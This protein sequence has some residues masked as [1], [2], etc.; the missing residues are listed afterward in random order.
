MGSHF[1]APPGDAAHASMMVV[2]GC[3]ADADD[4]DNACRGTLCS[5]R[6]PSSSSSSLPPPLINKGERVRL[7]ITTRTVRDALNN[8]DEFC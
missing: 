6:T 5:T 4:D 7:I 2:T 8:I 1:L 3:G